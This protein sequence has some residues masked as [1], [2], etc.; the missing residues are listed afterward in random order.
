MEP[1]AWPVCDVNVMDTPLLSACADSVIDTPV[2]HV[3]PPS[4]DH[5][6]LSV[7]DSVVI[8]TTYC[9]I[10]LPLYVPLVVRSS[11]MYE[12]S[13]SPVNDGVS[14]HRESLSPIPPLSVYRLPTLK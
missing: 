7:V 8:S 9:R 12:S 14:V 11:P 6:N 2:V 1:S 4:S 3:V 13:L 5:L 10:E